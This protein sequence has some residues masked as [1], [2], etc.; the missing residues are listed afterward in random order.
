MTIQDNWKREL[1]R[2]HLT[3]VQKERMVDRARTEEKK[4]KSYVAIIF[5][6]FVAFAIFSAWLAVQPSSGTIRQTTATLEKAA[7][8]GITTEEVIWLT[9]TLALMMSAYTLAVFSLLKV[10]RWQKNAA[11]QQVI[12]NLQSY[13]IVWVVISL[14]CFGF[15]ITMI[16]ANLVNP[17]TFLQ[18]FFVIF[19]FFN[20]SFIQILLTRNA[21]RARCPHCG[22]ELTSKEMLKKSFMIYDARCNSCQKKMYYD[23]KKNNSSYLVHMM[24]GP[25]FPLMASVGIPWYIILG[26]GILYI[27]FTFS[28]MSYTIRFSTQSEEQQPPLW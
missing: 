2:L 9:L 27:I 4:K 23:R 15:A 18:F 14:L 17:T 13:R 20:T 28:I 25:L 12:R 16:A 19:L 21:E 6:A 3:E 5:P 22:V 8:D 10:K 7:R 26:Y 11:V 1:D 24:G